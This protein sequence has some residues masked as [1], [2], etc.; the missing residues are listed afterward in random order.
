[1]TADILY[2]YSIITWQSLRKLHHFRLRIIEAYSYWRTYYLK[3][4]PTTVKYY[5]TKMNQW[6]VHLCVTATF[7]MKVET[8]FALFA[9]PL[10]KPV[11]QVCA[12]ANTAYSRE[13]H[14]FIVKYY[15]ASKLFSAFRE[16]FNIAYSNMKVSNKTPVIK[17]LSSLNYS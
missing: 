5:G 1:M 13:V 6:Q 14:A 3:L 4:N 12:G 11:A 8:M 15:F 16:T 7:P 10:L 2:E 17:P 9:R